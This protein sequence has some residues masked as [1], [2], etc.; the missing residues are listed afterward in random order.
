MVCTVLKKKLWPHSFLL[1]KQVKY[2]YFVDFLECVNRLGHGFVVAT[3]LT[4][5]LHVMAWFTN[6]YIIAEHQVIQFIWWHLK[7]LMQFKV[8]SRKSINCGVRRPRFDAIYTYRHRDPVIK[9]HT[10]TTLILEITAVHFRARRC[11][12]DAFLE[13]EQPSNTS[14]L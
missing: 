8:P 3:P 7:P 14:A 12:H 5:L 9:C 11:R 10:V 13:L 2:V 4:I 6:S 1:I